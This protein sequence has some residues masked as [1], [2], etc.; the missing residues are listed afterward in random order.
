MKKLI[1]LLSLMFL[2]V[3]LYSTTIALTW[4][5]STTTINNTIWD[6]YTA[7]EADSVDSGDTY[8][9]TAKLTYP[10]PRDRSCY[11]WINPAAAAL[12]G[13][14]T[15]V[16]MFGGYS[17]D[18]ALSVST[19]TVTVTDGALFK[20]IEAGVQTTAGFVILD[21]SDNVTEV[22]DKIYQLPNVPY[23]AFGAV[24]DT[25][26]LDVAGAVIFFKLLIPPAP[27]KY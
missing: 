19:Q 8:A 9:Y 22:T 18:F 12:D 14:P 5:K 25:T 6:V 24:P 4:S 20:T 2:A 10:L 3:S 1:I 26:F 21:P 23:I 16:A 13:T 11:L 17:S 7:T 15:S 27:Q